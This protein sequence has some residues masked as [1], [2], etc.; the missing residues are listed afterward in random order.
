MDAYDV[1]RPEDY[2]KF[3]NATETEKL[4]AI[5]MFHNPVTRKWERYGMAKLND[6]NDVDTMHE[7]SRVGGDLHHLRYFAVKFSDGK[8]RALR[9]DGAHNDLH[10][11]VE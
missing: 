3:H 8:S 5:V 10:I 4:L 9:L 11:Y 6:I 1:G 2:V 7:S